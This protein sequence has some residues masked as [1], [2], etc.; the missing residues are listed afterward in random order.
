M[1]SSGYRTGK[2][3][4]VLSINAIQSMGD[5]GPGNDLSSTY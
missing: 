3:D 4:I 1:I 2:G 5:P